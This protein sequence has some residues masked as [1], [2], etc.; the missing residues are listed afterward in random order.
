M[1][2]IEPH[3]EIVRIVHQVFE[4]SFE[5]KVKRRLKYCLVANLILDLYFFCFG[6]KLNISL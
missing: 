4:L 5:M 3:R 6:Q 1:S 2:L